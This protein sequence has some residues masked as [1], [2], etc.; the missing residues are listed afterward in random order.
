MGEEVLP[1]SDEVKLGKGIKEEMK[2]LGVFLLFGGEAVNQFSQLVGVGDGVKVTTPSGEGVEGFSLGE[3]VE[4]AAASKKEFGVVKKFQMAAF[5]RGGTT[6]T[7]GKA[8]K[9]AVIFGKDGEDS[10][11]FGEIPA[12][13]NDAGG[14]KCAH[15]S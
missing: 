7:F 15:V 4:G 5:A 1:S 3:E 8:N 11:G 13:E 12:V 9:F 14:G 2:N 6:D 10:I